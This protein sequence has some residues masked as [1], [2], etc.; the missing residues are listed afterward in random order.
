MECAHLC[1]GDN[2]QCRSINIMKASSNGNGGYKCQ[3]N[4][5]TKDNYVRK[6]VENADYSYFEPKSVRIFFI[7]FFNNIKLNYLLCTN[8]D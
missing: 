4:N 1:L 8:C 7:L 2:G 3:L 5:S 6:F